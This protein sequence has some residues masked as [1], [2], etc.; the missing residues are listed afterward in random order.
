MV[1]EN[2]GDLIDDDF[3]DE[4]DDENT[5]ADQKKYRTDK[6]FDSYVNEL[7]RSKRKNT[8][9]NIHKNRQQKLRRFIMTWKIGK[10]ATTLP[11]DTIVQPS[12][13]YPFKFQGSRF[14]VSR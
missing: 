8:I 2:W 7:E 6:K 1:E 10:I 13:K 14:Q 3:E 11:D 12:Q 5:S 9:K 4:L